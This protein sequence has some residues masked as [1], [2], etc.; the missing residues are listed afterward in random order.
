MKKIMKGMMLALTTC[1]AMGSCSTDDSNSS[2]PVSK[3]TEKARYAVKVVEECP[4]LEVNINES[5]QTLFPIYKEYKQLIEEANK[6]FGTTKEIADNGAS[7]EDEKVKAETQAVRDEAV[8]F[9][10]PKAEELRKKMAEVEGNASEIEQLTAL[11]S[12]SIKVVLVKTSFAG[13]KTI[14]EKEIKDVLSFN[15]G[16]IVMIYRTK[17]NFAPSKSINEDT[18]NMYSAYNESVKA[19]QTN[20]KQYIKAANE[21]NGLAYEKFVISPEDAKDKAKVMSIANKVMGKRIEAIKNWAKKAQEKFMSKFN[22]FDVPQSEKDDIKPDMTL[23]IKLLPEEGS[24]Y[25]SINLVDP[26]TFQLA[27]N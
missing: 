21:G 4:N 5:H 18:P 23:T 12:H 26:I 8:N 17:L 16:K 6:K 20:F 10:N 3:S 27:H 1:I 24:G 19:V 7:N 14:D 22:S 9:I 15:K 13:D 2:T 11:L 25:E